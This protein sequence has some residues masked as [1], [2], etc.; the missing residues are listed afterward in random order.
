MSE[1]EQHPRI[2]IEH[3]G[4]EKLSEALKRLEASNSISSATGGQALLLASIQV[5]YPEYDY[6]DILPVCQELASHW[7]YPD[8]STLSWLLLD[9]REVKADFMEIL[10][11][12]RE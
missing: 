5:R 2:T 9:D 12:R 4:L 1:R 3:D 7:P 6:Q 8:E 11:R 10:R